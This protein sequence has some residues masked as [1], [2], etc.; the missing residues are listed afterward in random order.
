MNKHKIIDLLAE[1][2]SKLDKIVLD[3]AE[4]IKELSKI[5][6][7]DRIDSIMVYDL[8]SSNPGLT[9]SE[10]AYMV[11]DTQDKVRKTLYHLQ[12]KNRVVSS[13]RKICDVTGSE[14]L[15]WWIK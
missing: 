8:V 3:V 9:A 7:P 13:G 4:A 1:T 15:C 14:A 2:Q 6:D 12:R 5:P 10:L 11:G